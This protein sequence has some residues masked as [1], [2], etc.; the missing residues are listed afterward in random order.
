M[1]LDH[2]TIYLYHA[3]WIMFGCCIPFKLKNIEERAHRNLFN[4][5]S[6]LQ[7]CDIN[8]L[9]NAVYN[10][11]VGS[12][13]KEYFESVPDVHYHNTQQ[14]MN[15]YAPYEWTNLGESASGVPVAGDL[16]CHGAHVASWFCALSSACIL[17]RLA[18]SS[19][20][21]LYKSPP[22]VHLSICQASLAQTVFHYTVNNC[23]NKDKFTMLLSHC[24]S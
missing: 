15:L 16:S 23:C 11:K 4:E 2:S 14:S 5:L 12:T 9:D 17:V 18:V 19:Q 3:Y 22:C 7:F 8:K 20:P 6:F 24:C 1:S 10:S 21:V 13:W